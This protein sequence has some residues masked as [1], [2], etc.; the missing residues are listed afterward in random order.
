MEIFQ[1]HLEDRL[2]AASLLAQ[3]IL[4][5]GIFLSWGVLTNPDKITGNYGLAAWN[6]EDRALVMKVNGHHWKEYVMITRNG[7]KKNFKI[8]LI[9]SEGTVVK[10]IKNIKEKNLLTVI[11][12]QIEKL[13]SY[14]Y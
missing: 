11:D 8:R 6:L 7:V 5:G 14:K 12:E 9:S 13:Q 2:H 4:K 10:T 1:N 3:F